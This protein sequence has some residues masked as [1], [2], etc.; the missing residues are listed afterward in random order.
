MYSWAEEIDHNGSISALTGTSP[1]IWTLSSDAVSTCCHWKERL[2]G[3][4][5]T[6]WV[7]YK[8]R[9]HFVVP[10]VDPLRRQEIY[11]VTDIAVEVKAD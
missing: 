11:R 2:G 7:D 6:V 10:V 1:A 8:K 9:H 3:H 4:R 5:E